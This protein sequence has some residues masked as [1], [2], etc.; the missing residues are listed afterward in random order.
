M[1]YSEKDFLGRPPGWLTRVGIALVGGILCNILLASFAISYSDVLEAHIE[2]MSVKPPVLVKT[3]RSGQ[4][5]EFF[6]KPGDTVAS[7]DVIA[8][9]NTVAD[10]ADVMAIKQAVMKRTIPEELGF[11]KPTSIGLVQEA[12]SEYIKAFYGIRTV[13]RFYGDDIG[14]LLDDKIRDTKGKAFSDIYNGLQT[15]KKN[16]TLIGRNHSRMETLY[17]KG[18]I[19]KAELEKS[20]LEYNRS[21]QEINRLSSEYSKNSYST[22]EKFD[23]HVADM[24]VASIKVLSE[25]AIWEEQNVFTSPVNGK[26]FFLDVWSPF[27]SVEEGEDLFGVSPDV[28]SPLMGIVKIPIHNSGKVKV[29]QRVIIKLN[30]FPYEEWGALEGVLTEISTVPKRSDELHY[31]AYVKIESPGNKLGTALSGK[32]MLTGRCDIVLKESTLFSKLFIGFRR[33]RQ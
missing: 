30:S 7:G 31:P 9:L 3:N 29:G 4:I 14:N 5:S 19:S 18:V 32:E 24:E 25:I 20:Q 27:Q 11:G 1:D 21:F 23:S 22:S 2:V 13:E 16:N 28:E 10:Y 12:Y 26:V 33:T 6:A 17:D 8:K 15:A